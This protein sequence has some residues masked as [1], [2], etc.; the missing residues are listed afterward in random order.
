MSWEMKMQA[1][2]NLVLSTWAAA[3]AL[4]AL[5]YLTLLHHLRIEASEA[6][7]WSLFFVGVAGIGSVLTTAWRDTQNPSWRARHGLLKNSRCC[8]A[9]NRDRQG[10][11]Q[12]TAVKKRAPITTPYRAG[13]ADD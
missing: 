2:P 6:L 1:S 13:T 8:E 11:R 7:Q 5:P 4:W 9:S 12:R 3:M 10:A